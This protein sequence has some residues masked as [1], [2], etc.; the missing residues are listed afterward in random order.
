MN[1][2]RRKE[3][4]NLQRKVAKLSDNK[5]NGPEEAI[6]SE[7]IKRFTMD[8]IYTITKCFQERFMGQMESQCSWSTC[9]WSGW[10]KLPTLTGT[11]NKFT[12]KTLGMARGRE[13]RDE[14]WY[15]GETDDVHGKLEHQ[16]SLRRGEGDAYC[17]DYVESQFTRMVD[18]GL[19]A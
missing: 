18:R 2:S 12:A 19:L 17:E 16:V 15:S 10:D 5:V 3:I 7:M 8:K 13:S 14:T 11:D 6:V 1:I 4:C 9:W